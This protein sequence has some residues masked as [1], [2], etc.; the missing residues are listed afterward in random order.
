MHVCREQEKMML[1]SVDWRVTV[2]VCHRDGHG[3]ASWLQEWSHQFLVRL[4][5]KFFWSRIHL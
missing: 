5:I 3:A 1:L 2:V 4:Q